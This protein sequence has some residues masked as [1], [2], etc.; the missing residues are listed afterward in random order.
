VA[1]AVLLLVR[2]PG[3]WFPIAVAVGLAAG[4]VAVASPLQ[5]GLADLRDSEAA[6][7]LSR[8]GEE[9]RST[10]TLWASDLVPFDVLMV[11]NGVP[12]LSGLQR[13][14]PDVDQWRRLDPGGDAETS[15]NRGGG[16]VVFR[17]DEGSPTRITDNGFDSVEVTVDPCTLARAFPE[18]TAV[19]SVEPL[20]GS[21]L[22][23]TA[24]LTWS[25][26]T[27]TVYSVLDRTSGNSQG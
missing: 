23:P 25:G 15:W 18:L 9:A 26:R 24:A 21:C 10:G 11:A 3:R 13:S 4:V 12:S 7:Y 2:Y 16:Y 19:A 6:T 1:L 8:A 20:G 5:R 17:W 27:V 22:E 14:G